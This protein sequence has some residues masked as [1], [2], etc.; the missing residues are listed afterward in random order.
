[1]LLRVF[2]ACY[3]VSWQKK[4]SINATTFP[5]VYIAAALQYVFLNDTVGYTT[6]ADGE[7][8]KH[9][10]PEVWYSRCAHCQLYET[11]FWTMQ[12]STDIQVYFMTYYYFPISAIACGPAISRTTL[13][14]SH[15]GN[16][17]HFH[18]HM[19]SSE[20]NTIT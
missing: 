18:R 15:V 4:V 9:V 14:Y 20:G 2:N 7:S 11:P 5:N 12:P 13:T 1:M 16:V 17:D 10:L 3:L 19:M 8:G 6:H